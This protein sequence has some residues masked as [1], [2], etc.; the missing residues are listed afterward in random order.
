MGATR[1]SPAKPQPRGGIFSTLSGEAPETAPRNQIH[2]TQTKSLHTSW[3]CDLGQ[4]AQP[5][6]ATASPSV[7]QGQGIISGG[8]LRGVRRNSLQPLASYLA[9]QYTSQIGSRVV[10]RASWHIFGK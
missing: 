7:I 3:L 8:L 6:W 9:R 10:C 4:V 5:L 1:P 2:L